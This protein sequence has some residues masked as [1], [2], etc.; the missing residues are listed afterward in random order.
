MAS[1]SASSVSASATMIE[2]PS[3]AAATAESESAASRSRQLSVEF[4]GTERFAHKGRT[5]GEP[6]RRRAQR[7]H[8]VAFDADAPNQAMQQGLRMAG[9]P[10]CGFI[11]GADHRPGALVEV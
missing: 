11:P 2:T 1:A 7:L 9:E 4:G 3:S 6:G 10:H 8:R 5:S